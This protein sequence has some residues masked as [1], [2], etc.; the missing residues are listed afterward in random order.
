MPTEN[1]DPCDACQGA[2]REGGSASELWPDLNP[3]PSLVAPLE[4][5]PLLDF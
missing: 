1:L 4:P 5:E 2:G 3:N